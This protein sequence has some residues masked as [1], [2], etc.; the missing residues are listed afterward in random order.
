MLYIANYEFFF[1]YLINCISAIMLTQLKSF[2]YL[3]ILI[4]NMPTILYISSLLYILK[5][6]KELFKIQT[7]YYCLRY[8]TVQM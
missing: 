8:N 3:S 7:D 5:L 6:E 4:N 1:K 2:I